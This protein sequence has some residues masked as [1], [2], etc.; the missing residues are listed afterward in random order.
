MP[1]ATAQSSAHGEFAG[2]T[3]RARDLQT[4]EIGA[5]NQE[6]RERQ[7]GHQPHQAAADVV[8]VGVVKIDDAFYEKYRAVSQGRELEVS[9]CF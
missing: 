9:S 3:E 7:A 6:H 2:A 8:H 4:R 1:L 5:R